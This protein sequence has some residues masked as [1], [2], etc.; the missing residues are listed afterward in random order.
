MSVARAESKSDGSKESMD[1]MS[2]D[3]TTRR[4]DA[5]TT[6]TQEQGALRTVGAAV[7]LGARIAENSLGIQ[8]KLTVNEPGD[9]YEREAERVADAVMR[10]LESDST[11]KPE[12]DVPSDRIQRLCPRCRR[13]HRL[14]QPMDCEECEA[15]LQRKRDGSDGDGAAPVKRAKEATRGTGRPLPGRT[16][17]FFER[18]M[19]TDLSDV[20]VHTGSEADEAARSIDA[21]AYTLGR[22]VVMRSGEYRPKTRTGRRLLAH[23]LAH[24]VQQG[25]AGGPPARVH[26]Q[27]DADEAGKADSSGGKSSTKS[28]KKTKRQDVVLMLSPGDEEIAKAFTISPDAIRLRVK[29]PEDMAK[30]LKQIT[31]P[32][33]RLLVLSHSLA[34]GDLGFEVGSKTR[35]VPPS[36]L[37]AKLK[38]AISPERGPTV[39]D[40]RGCSLGTSPSGME[41]IRAALH[42]ESAIGGNC[43]IISQVV[44]PVVLSRGGNDKGTRITRRGQLS[45]DDRNPFEAGLEKLRTVLGPAKKCILDHS[46][47]AYF[48]AG[49]HLVAMWANPSLSTDWDE[50]KSK[51]Y[52]E[53]STKTVNP[54]TAGEQDPGIVGN[55]ELIRIEDSPKE[56]ATKPGTTVEGGAGGGRRGAR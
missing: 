52:Q 48:R 17:S 11:E 47:D 33:G 14:G 42:A 1:T 49:G 55:C 41:Q 50:R 28:E 19:G 6:S 2:S 25:E 8:P 18:R 21:R 38:G 10:T 24:V 3:E 4:G 46:E 56:E 35:Y 54:A 34:D 51:C 43:F 12:G 13:R 45:K 44:G 32:I 5:S 29:S 39:V 36:D 37:A 26:R 31:K 40:F 27:E 15:K 9:K 23:E 30:K 7:A 22:D 20:R 53:L 16:R